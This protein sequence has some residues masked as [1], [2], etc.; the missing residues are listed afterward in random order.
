MRIPRLV[1]VLFVP[2]LLV[3]AVA[4]ASSTAT[5]TAVD[6]EPVAAVV[7]PATSKYRAVSSPGPGQVALTFDDGPVRSTTTAIIDILEKHR[8]GGT[9]F[10]VGSQLT[11]AP[12]VALRAHRLGHSVQNHTW[13]HPWL[14]RLSTA[15]VTWQLEKNARVIAKAIG[16]R[17]TVYRPPYG[18]R[19]SRVTAAAAK[20][21]Y[22]TIMWNASPGMSVQS[23]SRIAATI[24]S[25]AASLKRRGKG[26]N[27]LFHDGAGCRRC[28]VAALP[29]VIRDLKKM[30]FE[31]VVI[32]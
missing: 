31:F 20:L 19:N 9:F 27:V 18:A 23:A 32:R 17:P 21:G 1:G 14:T 6:G 12:D 26:V 3:P 22:P 28:I 4:S 8:V 29:L 25:Q 11:R 10:V 16:V 13:S 24:R 7:A 2:A 15:Q 30:G 5:I